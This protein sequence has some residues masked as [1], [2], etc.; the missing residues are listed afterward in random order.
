MAVGDIDLRRVLRFDLN[1]VDIQKPRMARRLGEKNIPC[2]AIGMQDPVLA[3]FVKQ[4][5]DGGESTAACWGGWASGE[6]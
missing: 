4:L 6:E 3:A 1:G 2:V 5:T